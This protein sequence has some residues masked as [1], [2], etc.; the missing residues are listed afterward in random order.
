MVSWDNP[1]TSQV[2]RLSDLGVLPEQTLSQVLGYKWFI[3]EVI[4][5]DIMKGQDCET[6]DL[7]DFWGRVLLG[8]LWG[9]LEIERCFGII[10]TWGRDL[11][12]LSIISHPS[13]V[14]GS[15][16]STNY[17][18]PMFELAEILLWPANALRLR[19]SHWC[20]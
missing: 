3:W 17:F 12:Y 13:L 1:Q 6:V 19:G 4:S 10:L 7:V 11:R 18:L 16:G 15:S 8:N 20:I 14:S 2:W 5:G 9:T